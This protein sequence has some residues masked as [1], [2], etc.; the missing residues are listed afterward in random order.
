MCYI[1]CITVLNKIMG[2]RSKVSI[3]LI[4][5]SM[6]WKPETL[7]VRISLPHSLQNF[8]ISDLWKLVQTAI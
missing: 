4:F 7:C 6:V 5:F 1:G 2:Y 8:Q 3:M